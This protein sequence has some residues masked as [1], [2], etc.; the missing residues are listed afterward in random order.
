MKLSALVL[1]LHLAHIFRHIHTDRRTDRQTD[2]LRKQSNR[3]QDIPKRVNPSKVGS[4]K[5]GRNY[6]I[7]FI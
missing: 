6:F 2:I 3:D 7:L 4:R 1:E 5:F